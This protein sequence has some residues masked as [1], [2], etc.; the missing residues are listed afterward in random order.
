MP[1]QGYLSVSIICP[2]SADGDALSTAL[3]C[4]SPE[5]GLALIRSLDG[6]EAMWVLSDGTKQ[7]S[8]GFLQYS[9]AN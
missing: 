7:F 9:Q 5:E 6:I 4:L 8:D 3:F 1:A 2:S